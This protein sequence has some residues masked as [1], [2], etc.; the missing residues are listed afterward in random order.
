[1]LD[2]TRVRSCVS[3]EMDKGKP[4][5]KPHLSSTLHA[6]VNHPPVITIGPALL[7]RMRQAPNK[8]GITSSGHHHCV[9]I[10]TNVRM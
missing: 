8:V 7:V 4:P 10:S 1:L 3:S 9:I 5:N 2:S 6:P